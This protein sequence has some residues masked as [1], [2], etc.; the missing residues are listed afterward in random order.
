MVA[1]KAQLDVGWALSTLTAVAMRA[2]VSL[3]T[4]SVTISTVQ[5]VT[6]GSAT[7]DLSAAG[8]GAADLTIRDANGNVAWT[9]VIEVDAAGAIVVSTEAG[10]A[11][12]REN[13]QI[14]RQWATNK[15][16]VVNNGDGTYDIT[17]RND[18]D[19]SD[20]VTVK[21]YN[22]QTGVVSVPENLGVT[23]QTF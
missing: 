20:V 7:V 23:E 1:I 3:G 18:G 15:R 16:T 10:D 8:A 14:A 13:A 2:G 9:D 17:L 22:P 11:A 12:S 6:L 5:T 4:G 19:T 21:A